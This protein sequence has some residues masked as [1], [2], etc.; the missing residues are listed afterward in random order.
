MTQN[1]IETKVIECIKA[2]G[3]DKGKEITS[4]T[5]PYDELGMDSLDMLELI[6]AMETQLNIT[7]TDGVHKEVKTIG[8][9]AKLIIEK[10]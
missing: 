4:A 5:K 9:F 2:F 1:E 10:L 8:E 3:H 6:E 7:F